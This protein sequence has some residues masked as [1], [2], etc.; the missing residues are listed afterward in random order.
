MNSH[1]FFGRALLRRLL[2]PALL[3]VPLAVAPP[4][5]AFQVRYAYDDAGR[6]LEADYGGG[7]TIAYAH[8]ANGN[9]VLR[10]ATAGA[11]FMLVYTALAGGV[12]D[13]AATQIV[14][15]GGSGSAVTAVTNPYYAFVQWSDGLVTASRT[16][17]NVQ[18]N[19]AVSAQFAAIL[20]AGGT[21]H[22]WLAHH[23][24]GTN[25]FDA[26]E[27]SDDDD[28]GFTAGQE[29]AAD[30]H[31]GLSNEFFVVTDALAPATANAIRFLSSTGRLYVLQGRA[32]ALESWSNLPGRGPRLG[33]GG[34]DG[35]EPLPDS[36][37]QL[38]RVR[39]QVP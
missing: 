2:W 30:T 26:A 38:Y 33:V 25:D 29:Y 22:W 24:P 10:S 18:S 21:P 39:V 35:M 28:D 31:P 4:A 12:L 5:A 17:A 14:A 6:L 23:Y 37:A 34:A 7:Q 36:P 3:L 19:L 32:T 16:D 13:G 11:E 1:A 8:D 9:L 15:L 27:A 20:A